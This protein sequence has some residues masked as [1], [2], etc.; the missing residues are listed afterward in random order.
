MVTRRRMLLLKV[1]LD[2]VLVDIR[3]IVFNYIIIY[4]P[5]SR[6]ILIKLEVG[7][8][9]SGSRRV[10]PLRLYTVLGMASPFSLTAF[11]ICG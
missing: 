11:Y 2:I 1:K 9:I 7:L 4:V 3:R 8:G 10:H 6:Y 5:T